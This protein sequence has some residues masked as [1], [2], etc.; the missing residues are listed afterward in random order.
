MT[1]FNG[2]AGLS[3]SSNHI[4]KGLLRDCSAWWTLDEASGT[5]ADSVGSNDL[6]DNNTVGSAAGPHGTAANFERNNNEYLSAANDTSL[7]VGNVNWSA[8]GWLR[9]ESEPGIPMWLISK[10]TNSTNVEHQLIIEAN[11]RV[12]W[13]VRSDGTA[14]TQTD[15]RSFNFGSLSVG[16]DYFWAVKHDADNDEIGLSINAGAWDTASHAGGIHASTGDFLLGI[17]APGGSGYDGLMWRTAIWKNHVLTSG[18]VHALYNG[19][20]GVSID[21]LRAFGAVV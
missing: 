19:G 17:N 9:A 2:S 13:R 8:C 1:F 4:I 7:Q 3:V 14:G 12:L 10:T 16:N 6:T 21:L 15:V 11:F 5:R 18:E 20:S